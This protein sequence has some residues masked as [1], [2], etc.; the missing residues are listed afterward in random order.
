MKQK[1]TLILVF[2]VVVFGF[3]IF[4]NLK[5]AQAQTM[6]DGDLIRAQ[7]TLDVYI[8]KTIG[9]K[10]FK[11]HILN[12]T[13]FESYGHLKWEDIKDVSQSVTNEYTVSNLIMEVYP[14]GTP[15]NGRVYVVSAAPGS[16]YGQKRFLNLTSQQF[17]E[18]GYDWSSIYFV[19]HTEASD[20]FYARGQEITSTDDSIELEKKEE[21]KEADL[22]T[23][24]SVNVSPEDEFLKIEWEITEP[25]ESSI[26]IW[27]SHEAS[28]GCFGTFYRLSK[29]N[30]RYCFKSVSR[31]RIHRVDIKYTELPLYSIGYEEIEHFSRYK[32]KIH[33]ANNALNN[34]VEDVFKI[35]SDISNLN[36]LFELNPNHSCEEF[37]FGEPG[38]LACKN[39][40]SYHGLERH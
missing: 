15:V 7:G 25:S 28:A 26:S 9:N 16:D 20:T 12:P 39:Y 6:Q 17:Y 5:N 27:P 1:I 32:Y 10:K 38:I 40:S 37:Y 36:R 19:N 34:E 22:I 33:I 4:S 24:K 29:E 21:N 3:L 31:S 23:I 11:R 30:S 35:P 8:V 14:N 13:I 18:A 2:S